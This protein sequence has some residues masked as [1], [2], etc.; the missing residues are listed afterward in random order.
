[1]LALPNP[2]GVPTAAWEPAETEEMKAVIELYGKVYHLWQVDK[3]H[4]LPIGEAQL[5]TSFTDASQFD[6]EKVVAD[7]DSRF[8]IDS[9]VKAEK[10]K[11]IPEPK[12]H[13]DAD[14][15]WKN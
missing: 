5:M 2:P 10:R 4:E 15:A 13:P 6:M 7:R 9:K 8:G 14:W 1:M 11:D 12:I 3:G